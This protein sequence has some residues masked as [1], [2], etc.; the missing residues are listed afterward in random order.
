MISLPLDMRV[1]LFTTPTDMRKGF[2]TLALLA[3]EHTKLSPM[4]GGL[5]VFLSRERNKVKVLAWDK[6]GYVL[7]YKR[8]EAGAFRVEEKAGYEEIT[9]IDLSM[10][11]QGMDLKRIKLRKSAQNGVFKEAIDC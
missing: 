9:G 1:Y 3:L 8:L 11:L 7:Y 4:A 6:D 2:D 10:L 5:F